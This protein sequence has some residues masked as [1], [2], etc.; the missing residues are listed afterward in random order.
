MFSSN[1]YHACE[2]EGVKFQID[3]DFWVEM[4]T[5]QLSWQRVKGFV[6]TQW[7]NV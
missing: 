6:L 2:L 7:E 3:Q 1:L 5:V 4:K